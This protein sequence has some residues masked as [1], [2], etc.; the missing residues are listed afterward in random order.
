[1]TCLRCSSR[2]WFFQCQLLRVIMKNKQILDRLCQDNA[3]IQTEN[4]TGHFCYNH[5]TCLSFSLHLP[6]SVSTSNFLSPALLC[7]YKNTCPS[8]YCSGLL[9]PFNY[10]HGNVEQNLHRKQHPIRIA[11]FM[12]RH[13]TKYEKG[14]RKTENVSWG[15]THSQW[16]CFLNPMDSCRDASMHAHL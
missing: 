6:P 2:N 10:C 9:Y 5:I 8:L 1:M 4:G 12:S 7:A 3:I 14:E 13:S 16:V 15:Y 11:L